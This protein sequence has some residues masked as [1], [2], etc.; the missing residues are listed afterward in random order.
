M[1]YRL[2]TDGHMEVR[3]DGP[4]GEDSEPPKWGAYEVLVIF[5]GGIGV[6]PVLLTQ[7][8]MLCIFRACHQIVCRP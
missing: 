3:V 7:I 4:Y 6:K 5:A 2:T 8:P 1:L